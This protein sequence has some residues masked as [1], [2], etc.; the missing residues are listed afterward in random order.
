MTDVLSSTDAGV[1]KA[2]G[3]A[4][5]RRWRDVLGRGDQG[6]SRPVVLVAQVIVL[7][8]FLVLWEV[9]ASNG[10]VQLSNTSRPSEVWEQLTAFWESGQ[11]VAGARATLWATLLSLLVGVPLGIFVGLLLAAVPFLDKVLGPFLVPL[12]SLPRIALAPLFLLWFGL[13]VQ[14]KVVLGVSVVFF[15]MAFAAR[16]GLLSTDRD[17][18]LMAKIQGVNKATAYAKV[19][20]PSSVPM[21]FAGI[22][23]SVTYALLGVVASEMIAARDGLGIDI[24]RFANNLN[25]AGVFAVLL[26]LATIA[27]VL[28]WGF[29][30]LERWLLRWQ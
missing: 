24:V 27:T 3:P 4:P 12:N 22:R 21:I 25:V 19:V 18:M 6:P 5:R 16:A 29:G 11:L 13:S 17:L 20:L 8:G 7:A 1:A 23:L 14:A 26:V 15:V 10:W 28:S 2:A 9:A 30:R